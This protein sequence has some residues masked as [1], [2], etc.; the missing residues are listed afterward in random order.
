MIAALAVAASL[1]LTAEPPAKA[2]P[3][4]QEA[5]RPDPAPLSA[6]DAEIVAHLELLQRMELLQDMHIVD[7]D[8]EGKDDPKGHEDRSP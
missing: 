7:V 3:A 8:A 1:A 2:P 6:E 4:R 5:T